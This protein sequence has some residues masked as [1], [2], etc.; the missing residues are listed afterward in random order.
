MRKRV[1]DRKNVNELGREK[2][3]DRVTKK[4]KVV[5]NQYDNKDV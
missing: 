5:L 1:K 4:K 2:E 3:I